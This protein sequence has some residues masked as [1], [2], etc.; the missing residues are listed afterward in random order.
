MLQ[1]YNIKEEYNIIS[2]IIFKFESGNI[3][4]KELWYKKIHKTLVIQSDL[5]HQLDYVNIKHSAKYFRLTSNV[6]RPR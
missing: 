6:A 4:S 5:K 2:S 1:T 3:S